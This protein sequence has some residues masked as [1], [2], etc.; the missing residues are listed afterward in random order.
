MVLS[1]DKKKKILWSL[2]IGSPSHRYYTKEN[3]FQL[4]APAMVSPSL[5]VLSLPTP[6][7]SSRPSQFLGFQWVI[8]VTQPGQSPENVSRFLIS[9]AA[10]AAQQST[11]TQAFEI[12]ALESS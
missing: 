7:N 6:P 5:H 11:G 12:S 9:Y 8:E 2:L 10:S 3:F 1:Q 4:S